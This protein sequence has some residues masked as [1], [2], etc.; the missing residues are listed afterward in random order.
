MDK[1]QYA[2]DLVVMIQADAGHL[3]E[4]LRTGHRVQAHG[5]VDA[6]VDNMRELE[7]T[8][9]QEEARKALAAAEA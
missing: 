8:V 6:I 7:D 4:A 3:A 9:G 1:A 2:K 5:F